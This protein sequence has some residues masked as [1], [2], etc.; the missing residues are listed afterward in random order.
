MKWGQNIVNTLN[1]KLPATKQAQKKSKN[2]EMFSRTLIKSVNE[3][4]S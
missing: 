4:S 2:L 3:T 1:E